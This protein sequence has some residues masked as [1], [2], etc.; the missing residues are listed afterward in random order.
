MVWPPTSSHVGRCYKSLAVGLFLGFT[1]TLSPGHPRAAAAAKP[2]ILRDPV[3]MDSCTDFNSYLKTNGVTDA[4]ADNHPNWGGATTWDCNA[5]P[6]YRAAPLPTTTKGKSCLAVTSLTAKFKLPT[7]VTVIDWKPKEQ[8]PECKA[9]EDDFVRKIEAHEMKH[10]QD[11]AEIEGNYSVVTGTWR[12]EKSPYKACGAT[13]SK[14]KAKLN[15]VVT[16]RLLAKHCPILSKQV[17]EAEKNFHG[18]QGGGRSP[19]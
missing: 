14:A 15:K 13:Q 8:T 11:I 1:G 10:V 2:T 19:P 12:A 17:E 9:E 18:S 4:E 3:A 7:T 16:Q 6:K 5:T